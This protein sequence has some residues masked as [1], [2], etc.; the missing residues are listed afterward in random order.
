MLP[1][2]TAPLAPAAGAFFGERYRIEKELGRGGMGQVFQAHD[3]ELDRDVALKVLGPG[4]HDEQELR[5]FEQEARAA[6]ALEHPNVV[7]VHDA[8]IH[9][10]ERYIISELLRGRTLRETLAR[11]PLALEK[12]LDFAR[13]LALGLGAAHDKGVIHRDLKPENL[14]VTDDGTLKILD[15]GLAKLPAPSAGAATT[16]AGAI[17]GT[18]GYMA[19][20]QVRGRKVDSRADLFSFGA[21]LYE[22]LAGRRAFAGAS[23]VE[24]ASAILNA[25]PA[26]L[27]REVPRRVAAVVRRCLA[28][29]PAQ[30][31]P[32]V[33]ALRTALEQAGPH[34]GRRWHTLV[35]VALLLVALGWTVAAWRSPWVR[36]R[37]AELLRP[38]AEPRRIA[39]LPFADGGGDKDSEAFSAGVLELLNSRLR[40]LEPLQGSLRLVSANDLQRQGI[41]T[42]R[43]AR[44]A[45]GASLALTGTMRWAAENVLATIELVDTE[46]QRALDSRRI[47][48][49]R[50]EAASLP[51]R[52]VTEVSQMLDVEL[53][54][55][56]AP[57][58]G[59]YELY[60]QG[61]GYLQRYDRAESLDSA[62]AVLQKA[63][64]RA[65][66]YAPAWARKAEVSL[67][68]FNLEKEPRHLA[69]ARV[70]ARRAI[71]LDKNL[72]AAQ[73]TMGLI[74]LAAGQRA[75]AVA[76]LEKA[77]ALE[78]GSVDAVRELAN[79]YDSAGRTQE[80]ARTLRHAIELR[81]NYWAAYKDLGLFY[82]HHGRIAEAI[83]P[84]KSVI[85]L[86]PDN[87]NGYSNLG[88]MYLRLGRHAEAAAMF[89]HSLALFPAAQAYSNL[90]TVQYFQ[91]RYREAADN[92]QKALE[93][94]PLDDR[95]WGNLA[96]AYRW[97]PGKAEASARA[98]REAVAQAQKQ[99][100]VNPRDAE[101]RSRLAMYE[102][103][104]G[105]RAPAQRD[106]AQALQASPGDGWVLFRSA[107]V[108]EQ[109]G[110]RDR[111]L[112]SIRSALAG[113]FSQEE[114]EKAPPLEKLRL[115]PQY[116]QLMINR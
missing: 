115:D 109:S 108:Y 91:K 49:P 60:L 1:S 55:E 102:I 104:L 72:A 82:N 96:D 110:M 61:C 70:S 18:V 106:I 16:G 56:A 53:R 59:A 66:E 95:I 15:F 6:G 10:G 69:D 28:K 54:P 38:H 3:L 77:T 25:D 63:V 100:A 99:L 74:E 34:P 111:A 20:E 21:I 80:A 79:A 7:A 83:A 44:R 13:Q 42:P 50:S 43:D 78:P 94:S 68:R 62:M 92:Y 23:P 64:L 113:G 89:E 58:P 33:R 112:E 97:V 31:Y 76:S 114:V 116:Q 37:F 26:A 12:A 19:P 8:G 32:S 105:D 67:R 27:P 17:L 30:R 9:G 90:G 22:M 48:V 41:L 39:L 85:D 86:T 29:D 103:F 84:F 57:A 52:L 75:E 4:A 24:T 65:P 5:R 71:E 81:P 101:L 73:V 47:E 45:F 88:A 14:F 11:G 40:Q 51:A 93:L 87:Y 98:Y 107:L 46:T 2:P 35:E 36:A